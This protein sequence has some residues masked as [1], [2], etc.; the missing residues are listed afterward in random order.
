VGLRAEIV[1][2]VIDIVD[3]C[4][5]VM[6]LLIF[7]LGFYELFINKIGLAEKSANSSRV[8]MIESLDDL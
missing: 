6:V 4:L 3:G 7:L 1:T 8:L 5:L 2:H